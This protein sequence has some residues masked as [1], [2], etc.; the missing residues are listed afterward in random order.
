M[1]IIQIKRGTSSAV[2]SGLADGELAINLDN[3]KIY[4]GSGST[5]INKF[6][7]A[8]LIADKAT[9]TQLTS[10]LVTASI[11]QTEGS[12]IFGDTIADTQT[13]NGHVTASGAIS[14]SGNIHAGTRI[15]V[16]EMIAIGA[17]STDILRFGAGATT[18]Q[19]GAPSHSEPKL[20]SLNGPVTAS[21]NISA[22]GNITS[23]GDIFAGGNIHGDT[24]TIDENKALAS[25][26]GS[27]HITLGN[28]DDKLTLNSNGQI[29]I[30]GPI[31]ASGNISASGNLIGNN[32]ILGS[33]IVLEESTAILGTLE[34]VRFSGGGKLHARS[35]GNIEFVNSTNGTLDR[36]FKTLHITASGNISGSS[37]SNLTVGGTGN[38]TN[39]NL[40]SGKRITFA[41]D[42]LAFPDCGISTSHHIT[43]SGNISASGNFIGPRQFNLPGA[44][45]MTQGD[46]TY[47]GSP[48][49]DFASGKLHYL[50][51]NSTWMLADKDGELTS[52]AVLLGFA[53]GSAVTDGILLRGMFRYGSDLGSVGDRIYVGD[54]GVP[55]ND[56]SGFASGDFI[57]IIGY[58]LGGTNGE[59]WFNPDNTYIE[60]A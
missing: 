32:L 34:E 46:I 44:D 19:V 35:D 8:E 58:L 45:G 4:Y 10:S 2:P 12:N 16:D 24:Y 59:L 36:G 1:G 30:V 33:N 47:F 20:I 3:S 11:I 40:A 29:A 23:S 41:N 39:L 55:T 57:R 26:H 49:P 42:T 21:G 51:S 28:S 22:S 17:P 27:G 37:T 9:I 13:F 53:L 50:R 25:R 43:A 52:G 38:F 48:G 7:L 31:T 15:R 56:V 60:K 6:H 14:A 18:I 5:S 54:D